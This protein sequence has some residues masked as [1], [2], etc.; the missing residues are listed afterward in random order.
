MRL[1]NTKIV[2]AAN[3]ENF[4]QTLREYNLQEHEGVWHAPYNRLGDN[5]KFQKLNEKTDSE[6]KIKIK[7]FHPSNMAFVKDEMSFDMFDLFLSSLYHK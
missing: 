6:N 3:E 7:I 1:K 5:I 4:Y 2:L